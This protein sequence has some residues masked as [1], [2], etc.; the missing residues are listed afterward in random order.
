[1]VRNGKVKPAERAC[2]CCNLQVA[3]GDAHGLEVWRE[4][5]GGRDRVTVDD[6]NGHKLKLYVHCRCLAK[7]L[8]NNSNDADKLQFTPISTCNTVTVPRY[9]HQ[10]IELGVHAASAQD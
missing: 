8:K 1:M 10:G 3:P 5:P 6:G 7:F 2:P 4:V 9:R